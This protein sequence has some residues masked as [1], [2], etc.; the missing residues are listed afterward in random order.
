MEYRKRSEEVEAATPMSEPKHIRV[1]AN[2]KRAT[3]AEAKRETEE[4]RQDWREIES[5]WFRI[6]EKVTHALD[7]RVP[8]ALGMSATAWKKHVFG[9][10]GIPR[11][12]RALRMYRTL[13][14]LPKEKVLHLAEGN[15][16]NLTRLPQKTRRSEKW[17]AKA[18]TEKVEEFRENVEQ[19]VEKSTG[20]TRSKWAWWRLKLPDDVHEE[21]EQAIAKVA[22]LAAIDIERFPEKRV[23]VIRWI[24][25][26]I[27]GTDDARLTVEVEGVDDGS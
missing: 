6:G 26:L 8:D 16:Y 22:R 23:T 4:I 13:G 11:I 21:W 3:P 17:L 10:K 1:V 14:D 5:S 20:I 9:L 25:S 18:A 19:E 2:A 12:E 15:A 27:N 24:A 7:R